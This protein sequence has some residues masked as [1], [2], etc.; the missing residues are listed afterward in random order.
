MNYSNKEGISRRAAIK[1]IVGSAATLSLMESG[2][3]RAKASSAVNDTHEASDSE[4]SGFGKAVDLGSCITEYEAE[5]ESGYQDYWRIQF[6]VVSN[7]QARDPDNNE[8]YDGLLRNRSKLTSSHDKWDIND[9]KYWVGGGE[10]NESTNEDYNHAEEA[11]RNATGL[12][13]LVG[14]ALSAT[15]MIRHVIKYYEDDGDSSIYNR[16]FDWGADVES[17]PSTEQAETFNRFDA[18]CDPGERGGFT[19][20]ETA[21]GKDGS[22]I[23]TAK[24]EFL[25]NFSAPQYSPSSI[26]SMSSNEREEKGITT[27]EVAQIQENPQRFGKTQAEADELRGRYV[28]YAPIE[29]SVEI[30]H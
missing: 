22:S 24:N 11:A 27:V 28:Y 3:N 20:E 18:E 4:T 2:I 26:S 30:R 19:L 7:T 13:P 1:T 12:I 9:T 17:W 25:V 16:L 21:K 5:A 6:E 29:T 14:D 23:F 10:W 15:Q 8:R